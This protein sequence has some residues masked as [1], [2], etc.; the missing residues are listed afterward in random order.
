MF[1]SSSRKIFDI[2]PPEKIERKIS[3]KI[4]IGEKGLFQPR[5][6]KSLKIFFGAII[7]LLIFGGVFSYFTFQKAEII[8]WPKTQEVSFEEKI[9]VDSKIEEVEFSINTIPG[10]ILREEQRTTQEFSSSGKSLREI[11]AEGI[12]RVYNN[13]HL[14][15]I[16]VANTRF[17]PPLER[18]L[19]FRTT[20]RITIPA[21]SYVDVE[22]IADKAGEEYNIGPSTFSVPGLAGLPQY[23]F[24]YGKSFESMKR[25]LKSEVPEVIQ[26]DFEKA[27]NVLKEK[28]LTAAKLSLKNKVSEEVIVLE[29]ASKKDFLAPIFS[30]K[31]G[32]EKTSFVGEGELSFTALTFKKSDLEDFIKEYIL[33]QISKDQKIHLESLKISY[34]PETVNIDQGK[35]ILSLKFS[36]KIYFKILDYDLKKELTEKL[37]SKAKEFLTN[38]PRIAKLE[39]SL[40]PF[41]IKK[42]PQDIEK[43]KIKQVIDSE[44]ISP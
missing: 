14:T 32:E 17:Q 42:V 11:K 4:R 28:L 12:I 31:A 29:K 36:A 15:Q 26:Q 6:R 16:L 3:P 34:L 10:D 2:I 40:W 8:I 39:I 27:E 37:L 13:Y 35:M 38:D 44:P 41:W 43:I 33:S 7:F 22:V 25:G 19:Y 5:P 24:V 23:T 9:T 1:K 21:K 20:R 30:A 18:V